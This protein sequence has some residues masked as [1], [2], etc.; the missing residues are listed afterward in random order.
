MEHLESGGYLVSANEA[1]E[2]RR[3]AA[4]LRNWL[5]IT[6]DFSKP[7][8]VEQALFLQISQLV[9]DRDKETMKLVIEEFERQ[10]ARVRSPH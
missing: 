10:I 6:V 8:N 5:E 2:Y 4:H 7:L 3:A 9:I 1:K